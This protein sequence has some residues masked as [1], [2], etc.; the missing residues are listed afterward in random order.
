MTWRPR[1]ATVDLAA[2]RLATVGSALGV[3]VG[4]VDT[5]VGSSIRAWVGNKID[6]TTLGLATVALS[7]VALAAASAWQRPGG[8]AGGRRLA[9]VLALVVP[10]AI[11]FTTIGRLWYV[12]GALM[13]LAAFLVIAASTHGEL[14][15]ALTERR[16]SRGLTVTLGGYYVFLGADA[17]GVPGM[18]GILGGIAIW[19]ALLTANHSPRRAYLLLTL[20]ALPFALAT[21][22]SVVT[23][24]TALLVV[25]IGV[26]ALRPSPPTRD[27]R[28]AVTPIP[29]R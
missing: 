21:W 8:H 12:P 7:A 13:L 14:A 22:W 28:W 4:V 17:L 1:R 26:R 16:W 27:G 29:A 6:T 24:L 25:A 5:A 18:L 23:P 11:C 3:I 2:G 10:A 9:T 19:A 15:G 20:G